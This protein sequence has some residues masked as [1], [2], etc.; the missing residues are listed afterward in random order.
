VEQVLL[1]RSTGRRYASLREI[2]GVEE[3]T[4]A[5]TT[6]A[7]AIRL[8]RS[9]LVSTHDAA[10]A[11]D[12]AGNLTAWERDRLLA[13]LY[14][15]I[16]GPRI[17]TT[18]HCQSCESLFDVDF[19]LQTLMDDLAPEEIFR[20]GEDGFFISQHGVHFRLPTGDDEC[21]V[22]GLPPEQA[23]VE[24]LQRCLADSAPLD[25]DTAAEVQKAM[26]ALSPVVNVDLDA[27]CP[28]CGQAQVVQFDLQRY[29]LTALMNDRRQL[30]QEIHL[31][32]SAYGWSLSEILNLTRSQRRAF[33][34]LVDADDALPKVRG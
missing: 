32:A 25:A 30:V 33:V 3:Q 17:D 29:L 5:S 23:V 6:T 15:R 2:T 10:L 9:L 12:E 26:Q 22:F 27:K 16:Y 24:L 21:A 7:D 13:V 34:A 18:I 20:D 14:T 28:E 8:L 4:V 1:H 11:A 19:I 31:L